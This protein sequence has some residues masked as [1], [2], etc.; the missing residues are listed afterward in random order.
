[1]FVCQIGLLALDDLSSA[2]DV[3]TERQLWERVFEQSV[4]AACLV[5]I[6]RHP[7]LRRADHIIILKNGR[8]EAQEDLD[9]LL[10]TCDKMRRLCDRVNAMKLKDSP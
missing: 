5:A 1:M 10:E 7:A 6:H 4:G 2:L 8:I 3:E 9:G